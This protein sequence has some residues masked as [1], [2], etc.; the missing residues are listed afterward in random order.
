MSWD[1]RLFGRLVARL[2]RRRDQAADARGV[3][4]GPERRRLELVASALAGRRMTITIAA[5]DG[6]VRGAH[7]VM[8]ARLDALPTPDANAALL[9]ARVVVGAV[10]ARAPTPQVSDDAASA[11]ATLAALARARQTIAAE[12][13]GAAAMLAPIAAALAAAR[14]SVA[15]RSAADRA[16]AAAAQVA[17]GRAVAEVAADAPTLT[18]WLTAIAAGEPT[19]AVGPGAGGRLAVVPLCG[20]LGAPGVDDADLP[21]PG[22]EARP[23]PGGRDR[24][25]RARDRI[26]RRQLAQQPLEENPLVHSFEKVHTLEKYQGGKKRIDGADQLDEHGDALDELELDEVVRTTTTTSGVYRAEVLGLDDAGDLAAEPPA[27][28]PEGPGL[29]RVGRGGAPL[30]PR[31]VPGAD[32]RRGRP[33]PRRRSPAA[34]SPPR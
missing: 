22:E 17:L 11:V 30:P 33:P 15:A 12:L 3:A 19:V 28:T 31:L 9:L 29:R 34:S 1:E 18:P 21:P 5:G 4:V 24:A 23:G 13:P 8:P 2:R 27:P 25:G 14:P 26:K 16:L 32:R 7:L 6:G 10:M 20:W